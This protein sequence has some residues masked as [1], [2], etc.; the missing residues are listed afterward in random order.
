MREADRYKR[1]VPVDG[2][3][4]R[5]VVQCGQGAGH[6]EYSTIEYLHTCIRLVTHPGL[7][8][9]YCQHAVRAD[10]QDLIQIL[11]DHDGEGYLHAPSKENTLH[12]R[13]I[14]LKSLRHGAG[15][16]TYRV[17]ML[18]GRVRVYGHDPAAFGARLGTRRH[19]YA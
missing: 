12:S 18:V 11:D 19:L 10:F 3:G 4:C 1:K 8:C 13:G 6:Y 9:K 2:H 14:G 16:G 5:V 17:L 15:R 7:Q